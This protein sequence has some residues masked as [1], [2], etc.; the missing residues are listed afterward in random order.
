MKKFV[1]RKH[2]SRTNVKYY[3][4]YFQRFN[5]FFEIFFHTIKKS[6]LRIFKN[7]YLAISFLL[8]VFYKIILNLTNVILY[9]LE[10]LFSHITFVM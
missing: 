2:I 5:I 7:Q 6:K 3:H 9:N 8:L 1:T 10:L 4:L